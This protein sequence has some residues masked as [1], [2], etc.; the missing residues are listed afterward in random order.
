MAELLKGKAVADSIIEKCVL[1]SQALSLD[2]IT[3]TLAVFRIGENDSD[4]SYEKGLLK[5]AQQAGV[6]VKLNI[7]PADVSEADYINRLEECNSDETIHGILLFK[8]LPKSFDETKINNLIDIRKDV[9]CCSNQALADVFTGKKNSFA[10]CT[11]QAVIEALDY[12]NIDIAGKNAVVLGRSL[13]IGKPVSM[14]LLNRNATVTI[15]HSKTAGIAKI[16]AKADI[17]VCATGMME[18]VNKDYLNDGMTVI[19]VGI[20]WNEQKQKLCGDVLFEEAEP[21]V[22]AITPVPGGIGSIT[23]S[24]LMAHVIQAAKNA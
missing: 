19:D 9:D 11:A 15:C 12:Y 13:V 4:L 5:K 17:L 22:K 16:A 23:S 8:P 18:S 6:E 7:F 1:E 24:I 14:L 3:P 21:I 2:G 20:S 10:P